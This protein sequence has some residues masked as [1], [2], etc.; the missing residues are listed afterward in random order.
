MSSKIIKPKASEQR[1]NVL[2][3][4]AVSDVCERERERDRERTKQYS[5]L[6]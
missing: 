4:N 5:A 2:N 1:N 3:S 6:K